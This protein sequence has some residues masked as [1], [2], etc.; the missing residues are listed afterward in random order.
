MK[1]GWLCQERNMKVLIISAFPPELAPEANHALHIS[2]Q[3]AKSGHAVHVLCKKGSITAT[4]ENIVVHPAIKDWSWSDLP[5]LA[6]CV[7]DCRPDVVLLIY[8]GWVYHHNPMIT[9]LPTI[10]K[11]I[12][13]GIPCVTQF[14]IIDTEFPPRSYWSR[15]LRKAMTLW[16]GEKDVHWLFGTLLRDSV[17]IIVLSSPHRDRLMKHYPE[18][19]EKSVIIP[20]PPII[21]VCPDQ[22]AT[23]RRQI[24]DVI[25]AAESDFVLIYW[26]YIYPGK[27]VETLLEAFRI[28]CRRNEN[29][30]LILVGGSLEIHSTPI[31]SSDYYQRVQRLPETFGIA[32]KV[33]WT[34]RFNW[35]SD[36]GSRYLYGGDACVLPFDY[37]VTL[38]NSSLAAAS[39]H[40]VP[41]ISTELPVGRDEVLEHGENI[42]LCRPRD[43][44]MLAEAIQLM[45]ENAGLRERLRLGILN[46]AQGWHRWETTTER[47]VGV[48]ESA[49]AC[50]KVPAPPVSPACA[51]T[52]QAELNKE[53]LA[54]EMHPHNGKGDLSGVPHHD[55]HLVSPVS[56]QENSPES[57]TAPLVSVI[58]AVYNVEKF[59]RQCLDSLAHQTLSNI[60]IV[61]VNDASTDNSA[62]VINGYKSSCPNLQVISCEFNKG[63]ASVRNIGLRAAKGL[64][65]AFVDG[66]DW[67]DI[68][69]CEVLYQRASD[70]NADVLI[71]DA[72]VFYED[73]KIFCQFFDQHIRQALD[74]RLKTMPFDLRSEPRVL[75]LEPVA[76][77]KL[78]KRSFLQEHALHFE[79]GMNSYEDICFHFSVLMKARRISLLDDALFFYRQNRPGQI[80][81]RTS[82]K[83][84]EVFAVF[85]K[86]HENL[87]AWDA[88]DDI[89]AML[90]KVQLR[91]FDWLM[92]DRV[93]A[94]YKREFLAS[95]A[96]QFRRIPEAGFRNF[97]RQANPDELSKLFCMRRNWLYAYEQVVRR[98][99]PLY[100][101]LELLLHEQWDGVLKRGCHHGWGMLRRR[102]ISLVRSLVNKSFHLEGVENTLRTVND[103]LNQLTSIQDFAL[104]SREPLV[105]ACRINNHIL[106]LSR[107]AHSGLGDAISRMQNDYYLTQI[108]VFREGDTVIDVG[109]H[110]GM[111][112]IYLAKK[113]PFIKVYAIEPDPLN[114]ACLKRNI[115]LNRVTNLTALHKAMS[116][117]GRKRILYTNARESGWATID[118]K[119]A[120]SHHVLNTVQVET[121]TL[122]QLFQEY[123]ISHCRL[124][125]ITAPGAIHG[126]LNGFTRSG[127]VDLLCGEVDLG[128]CS[129]VQLEMA[130]WRIARQHFWRTI[131]RQAN[132]RVHS[133]L[134]Q[135]PTGIERP[136]N[137]IESTPRTAAS[138]HTDQPRRF[139]SGVT[140]AAV[141]NLQD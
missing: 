49:V 38:N 96:R 33:T 91:Q 12:L 70:D 120:S 89:W 141:P 101:W 126:S 88:P 133:W 46:L 84:F 106:F 48:L 26:G 71:A 100:P 13:P 54:F 15:A 123:Q 92:R 104:Q 60:E 82:R 29:M 44:E 25:G 65:V 39:T 22:P 32:D 114:Y 66:D 132:G 83:I 35:D 139:T 127:C 50:G 103:R 64:Y 27:G 24:R 51:A 11:I 138:L 110:V 40:G 125:K 62:Q 108:A 61:V 107:P 121:V 72:T 140:S 113:F 122:E 118:A 117:D 99:W 137:R 31:S 23:V 90:V 112:S 19:E 134:Q 73:T 135:I 36:E 68:K 58:V 30:R 52:R 10:C 20:P 98:R 115:E 53:K 131:A 78:Y 85:Q 116:E 18:V 80:S 8:I 75:L 109:A 16:A 119:M 59:L 56:L 7:K 3:L 136:Q 111:V 69:M 37:G 42:Y 9:F 14:E 97:A 130:S 93:Q 76:W 94:H 74:P 43:P 55:S 4:Q 47:L 1:M 6:K 28:V 45:S 34:G 57:V 77:T 105:E 5:R 81:A 79:D 67:V 124:L 87:V 63:L 2:E 17:R 129:R 102:V 41:V 21:R 128:D 95:V 86:I